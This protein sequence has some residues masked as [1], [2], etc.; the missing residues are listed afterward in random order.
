MKTTIITSVLFTLS[1]QVIVNA[2]S[3]YQS[4]NLIAHNPNY[5]SRIV[6]N[7]LPHQNN[8]NSETLSD[9]TSQKKSNHEKLNSKNSYHENKLLINQLIESEKIAEETSKK[10]NDNRSYITN[11][12]KSVSSDNYAKSLANNLNSEA[13]KYISRSIQLRK[14]AYMQP[15]NGSILGNIGNAEELEILAIAKQLQVIN[16]IE[17]TKNLNSTKN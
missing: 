14:E 3:H 8:N 5:N 15:N 13:E 17:R 4:N 2:Q 12:I 16:V 6:Y 7:N 9:V 11:L 10:L 1:V